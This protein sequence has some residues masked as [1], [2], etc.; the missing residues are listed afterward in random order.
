VVT[1]TVLLVLCRLLP[2]DRLWNAGPAVRLLIRPAG[3]RRHHGVAGQRGPPLAQLGLASIRGAGVFHLAASVIFIAEPTW[4][5]P[6][7]AQRHPARMKRRRSGCIEY[8]ADRRG[9]RISRGRK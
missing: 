7:R 1:I 8:A 2:L 5:I 6:I 3:L 4:R 9:M